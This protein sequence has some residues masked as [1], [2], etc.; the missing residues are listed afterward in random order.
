MGDWNPDPAFLE[1]LLMDWTSGGRD[2]DSVTVCYGTQCYSKNDLLRE[3]R[4]RTDFGRDT[5]TRY[6]RADQER[7]ERYTA[8]Q[9]Q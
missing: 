2:L 4:A 8:R 3:M 1:F 9:M 7:F 5:Y 6:F